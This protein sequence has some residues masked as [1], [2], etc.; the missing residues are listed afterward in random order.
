MHTDK[1]RKRN[2][3]Y[4]GIGIILIIFFQTACAPKIT[5]DDIKKLE[6][7]D[8]QFKAILDKKKGIDSEISSL[9]N[10]LTA[11]KLDLEARI[12]VLQEG[13][14]KKKEEIQAQIKEVKARLAPE[15]KKIKEKIE[16]LNQELKPLEQR[17]ANIESMLKDTR[18][19]L[20]K[21][22]TTQINLQDKANWDHQIKTLEMEKEKV[23]KEINSLKEKIRLY[24][25]VLRIIK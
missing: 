15:R 16:R 25:L 12:S 23:Q 3:F 10:T 18:G 6:D 22:Q 24:G 9:E 2:K 5:E 7:S 4:K 8:P 19:L 21:S 20:K 14:R 17:Y 13:F 1:L 11:E